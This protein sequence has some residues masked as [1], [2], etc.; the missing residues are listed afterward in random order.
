LKDWIEGTVV[1][2]IHWTENLFT[3]RIDAAIAPFTAGQFTSLALDIDGQRIAR[4]YS[5]LST[6]G[7]LPAEFFFYTATGGLLSN[8][9]IKLQPGDRIWI[10]QHA[11]GFFT[12]NEVPE[13]RDLW[14]LATGTGIAPCYS[15]LRTAE[16]WQRF[17]NLV[18]VHGVRTEADLRYLEL[19]DSLRA[20]YGERFRFQAFVSR[21]AVP[22]TLPGRIPAAI[23]DGSLEKAV[24][25]EL[26][27]AHSQLMLCGN[28]DMVKDVTEILKGRGF[29][30]NRRRTPGHITTENYW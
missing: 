22:G 2:N 20:Q 3:L 1:D 18:L 19:A 14:M 4:P 12:L 9:L 13:A 11:N 17:Q 28:P 26:D 29:T 6:P 16:P 8:A 23:E 25:L 15:I 21:E 27:P 7:E 10:R 5:Y 30:R 24:G